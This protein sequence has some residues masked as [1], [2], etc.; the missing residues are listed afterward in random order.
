MK[1]KT[2][3]TFLFELFTYCETKVTNALMVPKNN[4]NANYINLWSRKI[5]KSNY[6]IVWI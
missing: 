1:G 5:D 4:G 3:L 2:I 6:S